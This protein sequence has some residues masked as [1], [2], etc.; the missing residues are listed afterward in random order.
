MRA[1]ARENSARVRPGQ[2]QRGSAGSQV[3]ARINNPRHASG[4]RGLNNSIS[5]AIEVGSVDVGVAINEQ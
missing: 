3:A 2:S 5:I 1:Y 4:E